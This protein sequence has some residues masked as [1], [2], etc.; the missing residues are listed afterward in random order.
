MIVEVS[1]MY[2]CI[3]TYIIRTY[4]EVSFD[5]NENNTIKVCTTF[6]Y[7]YHALYIMTMPPIYFFYLDEPV[8]F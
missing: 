8:S 7:R 1:L 6:Q 4:K 5:G 3:P 2:A